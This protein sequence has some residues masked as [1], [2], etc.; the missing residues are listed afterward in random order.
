[1]IGAFVL[2]ALSRAPEEDDYNKA[3][4]SLDISTALSTMTSEFPDLESIVEGR[5]VLDFGCGAGR[6]SVALAKN[7][8]AQVT[9]V[10]TNSQIL[11][12]AIALASTH[13]LALDTCRFTESLGDSRYDVIITQ[14]AMEHFPNPAAI[15]Q[16]MKEHLKPGGQILVTFSPPWFAPY[17]HHMHFFCKL[18]WLNLMFS[19]KTVMKVRARYRSDGATRYTEVESGLNKMT[20]AKFERLVRESGLKVARKHYRGV[21]G[22]DFLTKIPVIRELFTNRVTCV[23]RL[24]A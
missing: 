15:L 20:L 10:D 5:S 21:K 18:P 2:G 3:V 16:T 22:L 23:L 7:L 12:D 11:K 14:N 8:G 9:G 13:N 4:P 6:Q 1:M 19:E 24:K 17:G